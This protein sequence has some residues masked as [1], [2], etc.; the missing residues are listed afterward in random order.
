MKKYHKYIA[1]PQDL[2]YYPDRA[3]TPQKTFDAM[4]KH[5]LR[6]TQPQL[7]LLRNCLGRRR[8]EI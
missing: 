7:V 2:Y 4:R 8:V 6:A 3:F 5:I 1:N